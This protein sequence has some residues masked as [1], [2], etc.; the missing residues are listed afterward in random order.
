LEDGKELRAKT[1]LSSAGPR[2]TLSGMLSPTALS[3]SLRKRIQDFRTEGCVAKVHFAL[4]ALPS[5]TGGARSRT[6]SGRLAR[7]IDL[8]GRVQVGER[9]SDLEKAFDDAKYG[10][11]STNPFMDLAFPTVL[12]PSLAPPKKH[13]CSALVQYAP[14]TLADGTWDDL[15][16]ELGDRVQRRLE[17]LAPGFDA[18]VVGREVLTPVDLEA[19]FGLDGGHVLGGDL[20]LDQLFTN[21][22]VPEC[23]SYRTPIDALYLTGG[24]THPG[25]YLTGASGANAARRI[26]RDWNKLED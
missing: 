6:T 15:R 4:D 5:F 10:R 7:P 2:R 1:V 3:P 24:G 17:E 22:P 20:S 26:L 25:G 8:G 14:Y 16:Q 12:D 19:R 18:S 21:R 13:V 9:L 23:G 11:L